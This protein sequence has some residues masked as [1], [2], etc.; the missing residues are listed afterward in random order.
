MDPVQGDSG[1]PFTV[2]ESGQHTLVGA[3]SFGIGCARVRASALL[4]II[5]VT[6]NISIINIVTASA[7]SLHS[8]VSSS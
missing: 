3:V 1:G 5:N 2:E 4:I 8:S 6:L 7:L